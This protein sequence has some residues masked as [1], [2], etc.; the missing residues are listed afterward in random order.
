MTRSNPDAL[1]SGRMPR[2]RSET[3]R[4]GGPAMP[5]HSM[6]AL[7]TAFDLADGRR[8]P[9]GARGAVVFVHDGGE[10][11]MVEFKAPFHAVT[12]VPASSLSR[13]PAVA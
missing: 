12:T 8:L 3:L 9:R 7:S 10:A 1:G 6:V 5:E 4:A 11:Y 13:A 2:R